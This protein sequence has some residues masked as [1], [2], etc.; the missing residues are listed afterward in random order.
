MT[1]TAFWSAIHCAAFMNN[2]LHR[3]APFNKSGNIQHSLAVGLISILLAISG[4]GF[5]AEPLDRIVA[6]A[7]E[8]V[9]LASE[10]DSAILEI[11][12]QMQSR[13]TPLP[14][15]A[16]LQEQVLDRLVL[17]RLQTQKAKRVGIQVDDQDLNRAL[18]M[19]A[20]R[21]N[22]STSEFLEVLEQQG[23]DYK[24]YR[25]Q[26]H[27]EL[28]TTRLR[29]REVDSRI[30]ITEQDIDLFLAAQ[31]KGS[32]REYRLRQILVSISPD[33]DPSD[34][35]LARAKAEVIRE[36]LAQGE[37]FIALA[38]AESDGQQ[39]L[40]G[41]DLGWIEHDLLPTV[42]SDSIPNM[43]AGEVSEVL[44]SASGFHIVRVDEIRDAGKRLMA[45]EVNARHI[46]LQANEIRDE[47]ATEALIQD[48][49]IQLQNGADF[50]ELAKEYSDDPGSVNQGGDLGWQQPASFEPRFSDRIQALD[51]NEISE[52]FRSQFGW[53]IAQVLG[54]RERDT[55]EL[56]K[57]NAAREAIMRSRVMDEYDQWLRKLRAEA[58]VEYRLDTS[59]PALSDPSSPASADQAVDP[60]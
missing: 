10:L 20:S 34:R 52:P 38:T 54:W 40:Q 32:G 16:I 50:A 8:E 23:V 60:G 15:N 48:L 43:E 11:T 59:K 25:K 41:G 53:H 58:Y 39:A 33:A 4:Q 44:P 18:E 2:S 47:G 12:R 57:R 30:S 56:Q 28:L 1:T 22:M 6:I 42:F 45:R 46:L 36:R 9:I 17:S 51:D 5:A 49:Y 19:V 35:R 31:S 7:G 24:L 13:G 26:M 3:Q 21:N 37:D 55:T 29:Q 27:D 14:P